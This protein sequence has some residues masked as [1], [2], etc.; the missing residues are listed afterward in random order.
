MRA[1]ASDFSQGTHRSLRRAGAHAIARGFTLGELATTLAITGVLAAITVPVLGNIYMNMHVKT[2]AS[3]FAADLRYA[4]SEAV[5]RHTV[6]DVLAP[7]ER[8]W[9]DGWLVRDRKQVLVDRSGPL[10]V[11]TLHPAEGKLTFNPRGVLT[12]AGSYS[13]LFRAPNYR[14]TQARCV[15]VRPDGR[16][17]VET[18]SAATGACGRR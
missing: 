13:V 9:R 18:D 17:I 2:V 15:Y 3:D 14:W 10:Q 8:G 16:P 7:G 1:P 5:S 11:Q 4:R 6:V 12:R